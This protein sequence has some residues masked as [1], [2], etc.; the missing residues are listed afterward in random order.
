[1]N[2]KGEWNGSKLPRILIERGDKVEHE[3]EDSSN[4][5]WKEEDDRNYW[6][7]EKV[8]SGKRKGEKEVQAED[9]KNN[10]EVGTITNPNKRARIE[11]KAPPP[12]VNIKTKYTNQQLITNLTDGSKKGA[13]HKVN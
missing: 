12:S 2:A 10:P 7:I 13:S 5:M 11:R 9:V 8:I 6:K 3:E 4:R 1:M